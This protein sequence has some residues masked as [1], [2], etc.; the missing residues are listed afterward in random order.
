MTSFQSCGL[1]SEVTDEEVIQ[2]VLWEYQVKGG[3][4]R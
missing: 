4:M 1:L 3:V 2:Y